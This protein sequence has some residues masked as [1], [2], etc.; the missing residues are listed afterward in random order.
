MENAV[1]SREVKIG[2]VKMGGNNPPVIQSMTNTS[3]RDVEATLNQCIRIFDR[4]AD[5]IR[6]TTQTRREVEAL[7]E[8]KKRLREEGYKQPLA[9]DVHFLP[10]VAVEAAKIVE[11]VRINPGNYI[12]GKYKG[13]DKF[14]KQEQKNQLEKIRQNLLPLI[15]ICKTHETAIRIGVNH[16]SLS[17]RI[18]NWYGNT[19]EG[20]VE[21]ALEFLTV[22]REEDFHNLVVSL[23]ASSARVMIQANRLMMKRMQDENFIYPVHLGV[24]EAG[25]EEQ[26]RIKSAVGI[27][28]LLADGIGDTLRVSLTEDPEQ[29]IPVAK[30]LKTIFGKRKNSGP[31]KFENWFFDP[32]TFNKRKS[33][34]LEKTGGEHPPVVISSVSVNKQQ[35]ELLT[36]LGYSL[37]EAIPGVESLS[38]DFI[39]IHD[40]S[41]KLPDNEVFNI[42]RTSHE[43]SNHSKASKYLLLDRAAYESNAS[44]GNKCVFLRVNR[45]TPASFLENLKKE[46]NGTLVFDGGKDNVIHTF[47][48]FF[49]LLHDTG[50]NLPV[51]LYRKYDLRDKEEFLIRASG[52]FGAL[53]VDG[54][55]DGIW[56]EN[57][58]PDI[59]VKDIRETSFDILQASGARI[60]KT[61]YIACPSC[62]RTL[63][64]IQ[65]ALKKIKEATAG[66]K[67]LKIAVMGCIV[68]G[69]GEMA[70][71]DFGY[72]GA[73][74]GKISLYKAKVPVKKNIPEEEA[75][76]E[77]LKLI[78][79]E[80]KYN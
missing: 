63:F 1:N 13:P 52:E 75:V 39:Y 24:T 27:C 22:F 40:E 42:I 23:K 58:Y 31:E 41:I 25:D 30:L 79:N 34:S 64:N 21:S 61:E 17:E 6:V 35:Q 9:A 72:V 43:K 67:G 33:V 45:N 8:I 51:I 10:A 7:A 68:N 38:A 46:F 73:G 70:D 78:R 12:P 53:F 60:S 71:A 65:S 59:G 4:G 16:G 74:P 11:K 28:S 69:P 29:E 66:F 18:L 32:F 55:G 26:G 37:H 3:T 57:L 5:M 48:Q 14:D 2:M 15:E 20:M 47:R 62:G 54:F 49:N 44:A 56:I 50:L 76:E 36:D 77:L 19:P 80:T